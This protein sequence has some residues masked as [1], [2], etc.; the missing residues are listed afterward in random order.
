MSMSIR[1]AQLYESLFPFTSSNHSSCLF[2]IYIHVFVFQP[3]L[4]STTFILSPLQDHQF[5]NCINVRNTYNYLLLKSFIFIPFFS[6]L[7]C[8]K[9]MKERETL[10][11]IQFPFISNTVSLYGSI[12]FVYVAL[13]RS[14]LLSIYS[15]SLIFLYDL[16]N[17]HKMA[18]N[19]AQ[20]NN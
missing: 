3:W 16:G 5:Y 15:F 11:T 13:C 12:F 20:R 17:F 2:A 19:E 18:V 9:K 1:E 10:N 6:S 7:G 8:K 14:I 4:I